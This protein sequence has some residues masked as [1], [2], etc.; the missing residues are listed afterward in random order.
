MAFA[1][2]GAG[3]RAGLPTCKGHLT[4]NRL[5]PARG[6][7]R[8]ASKDDANSLLGR[9]FAGKRHQRGGALIPVGTTATFWHGKCSGE[10]CSCWGLTGSPRARGQESVPCGEVKR[11]NEDRPGECGLVLP[12]VS[13]HDHDHP[14]RSEF[15]PRSADAA[16]GCGNV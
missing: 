8:A 14:T 6:R 1:S 5:C 9:T 10:S 16:P 12:G 3:L 13:H 11:C 15:A 4:T 2:P 7:P